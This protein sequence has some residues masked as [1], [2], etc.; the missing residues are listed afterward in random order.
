MTYFLIASKYLEIGQRAF[1]ILSSHFPKA[2]SLLALI[3][4]ILLGGLRLALAGHF[5]SH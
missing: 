4:S 1:S 3:V 2:G 5:S